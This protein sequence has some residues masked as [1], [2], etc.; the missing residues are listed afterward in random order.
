MDLCP[1][2][3]GVKHSGA[4]ESPLILPCLSSS[5]CDAFRR[6]FRGL[7]MRRRYRESQGALRS[8]Q[9]AM[10]LLTWVKSA[11]TP[12]TTAPMVAPQTAKKHAVAIAL[13]T[14]GLKNATMATRMTQ[15]ERAQTPVPSQSAAM[16]SSKWILAK[17][18]D[19]GNDDDGD[20]C[21][22]VM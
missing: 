8:R 20:G 18:A 15:T 6:R 21:T 5:D 14:M 2:V 9:L 16:A 19:D 17:P 10:V 3:V 22:V 4:S 7:S 11:M 13:F 12:T 1:R